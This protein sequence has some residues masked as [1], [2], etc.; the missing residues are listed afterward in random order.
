MKQKT[1]IFYGKSQV[2]LVVLLDLLA[3]GFKVKVIP[4]DDIIRAAAKSFGLETVNREV[5]GKYDLFVSCHGERIIPMEYLK[6][7]CINFH[8]CL[9]KYKGQTPV[10]RYM[11]NK[12]TQASIQCHFMT[13]DVDEGPLI[14]SVFFETPRVKTFGE[15][16]NLALPR[17]FECVEEVLRKLKFKK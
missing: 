14:H 1:A 15:Y 3:N 7:P 10:Q 4:N 6:G 5:M 2:G 13:A 11:D 12:D 8:D 16:Y 9:Y 17:Y